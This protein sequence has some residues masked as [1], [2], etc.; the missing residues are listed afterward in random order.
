M[1]QAQ[2]RAVN[3]NAIQLHLVWRATLTRLDTLTQRVRERQDVLAASEFARFVRHNGLLKLFSLNPAKD[4]LPVNAGQVD[5]ACGELLSL[6]EDVWKNRD[7]AVAT[8]TNLAALNRKLDILAAHVSQFVPP[9]PAR[10][11]R[12]ARSRRRVAT[13]LRVI[14]GGAA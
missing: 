6:C 8:E 10:K 9:G 2:A 5:K 7:V 14:T 4:P 1:T 11:A 3:D 12:R 13:A